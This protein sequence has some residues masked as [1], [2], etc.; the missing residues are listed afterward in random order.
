MVD[1]NKFEKVKSFFLELSRMNEQTNGHCEIYKVACYAA[2]LY[3]HFS[4]SNISDALYLNYTNGC[5]I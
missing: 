2:L 3:A 5:D 4:L 1:E